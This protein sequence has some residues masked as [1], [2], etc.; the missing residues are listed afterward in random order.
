MDV[1]VRGVRRL[2]A[3]AVVK[4]Q[5]GDGT[6]GV[7]AALQRLCRGVASDLELDILRH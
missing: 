3:L 6:P 5:V 1:S 7:A 2:R 4:G